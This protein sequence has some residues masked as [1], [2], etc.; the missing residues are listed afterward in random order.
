[1]TATPRTAGAAARARAAWYDTR[2]AL[3]GPSGDAPRRRRAAR[4]LLLG[5]AA[6]LVAYYVL[7]AAGVPD[8][9]ALA[10]GAVPPAVSAVL[11]AVR[12]RRVEPVAVLVL[13]AV[14]LGL[15]AT[16]ITGDP[17]ELLVR[18]A[19]LSL[20]FGLWLLVSLRGSRPFCFAATRTLL[21]HRAAAL[22]ELWTC[23]AAF[24]R[25][26]RQITAVWA[27]GMLADT[28]LRV[29]MASTL[30]VPV[31][32]ALDTALTVTTLLVLQVPTHLLLHRSGC[33]DLIFRPYVR[34][35]AG[36]DHRH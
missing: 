35:G 10:L 32:P 21:P 29:L 24:R 15:A 20:P 3:L 16:A 26:W 28:A 13:A 31:V 19:W 22:D 17:R 4:T 34:R 1:M 25:A 9:V 18:H 11:T 6:P 36:H 7:R 12:E 27:G 14:V 5:L 23:D 8:V 33:W 30:P 2:S